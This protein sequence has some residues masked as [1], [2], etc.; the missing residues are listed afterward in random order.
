MSLV[1]SNYFSRGKD[2]VPP[3]TLSWSRCTPGPELQHCRLVQPRHRASFQP[4]SFHCSSGQTCLMGCR[5]GGRSGTSGPIFCP[6]WRSS[7]PSLGQTQLAGS[8][9]SPQLVCLVALDTVGLKKFVFI[10]SRIEIV[11][12]RKHLGHSL[13]S[14]G[15]L[16]KPL[17]NCL[18]LPSWQLYVTSSCSGSS[19]NIIPRSHT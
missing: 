14:K 7:S 4:R 3:V 8:Q 19:S 1:W 6:Q 10:F 18:S 12:P 11:P 16:K 13:S 15:T 5:S 17:E 2:D 9:Y